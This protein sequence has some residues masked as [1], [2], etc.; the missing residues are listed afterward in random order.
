MKGYIKLHR[1]ILEW[2]W[3][4]DTNTKIVFIHLLLNAC[5]DKCR[6][7]GNAVNR[8]EYLTSINRICKDLNLTPRQVRTS[9]KRLKDTGEIDIQ[10]TNKFSRI[11]ICNYN[12]YQ[13][14]EEKTKATRTRKRQTKDT[15]TTRINK[16]VTNKENNNKKYYQDSLK[17]KAWV[18]TVCMNYSLAEVSLMSA[19]SKFNQHLDMTDDKKT[20][21]RDFK[22]HF[23]NWLKYAHKDFET[24]KVGSFKWKWKGQ[25]VKTGTETQMQK[26]QKIYDQPGFEFKI[27]QNGN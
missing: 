13:L 26:D 22:T 12:N 2:E 23:I 25:V 3:Y 4:K 11:S 17:N 7:M 15:Q 14:E 18:E 16:K 10:T 27:I 20:S 21:L 1:T 19:L 9:L 6:F 24:K 5:F 8:G